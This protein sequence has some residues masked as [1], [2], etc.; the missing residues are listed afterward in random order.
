MK[1]YE[2]ANLKLTEKQNEAQL[3]CSGPAKYVMLYGGARSGKTFLH[4]RNIV[5][6]GLKSPDSR[7]CIFRLRF[8]HVKSSIVLDTFPKVMR[9]AFPGVEYELNR[10][11]YYSTFDN[12]AVIWFGGL[13]DKD[14][15]EKILG[16][17]FCTIYINEASQI[18]WLAVSYAITRLAQQSVQKIEG[19]NIAPLK[20]RMLFDCNPPNKA[21]WTYSLFVKKIHPETRLPLTNP[22]EYACFKMNP[23]DNVDNLS[24]DYLQTLNSL[25]PRLRKRFLDGEFADANPNALFTDETMMPN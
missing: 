2:R 14:R 12:G 17:E 24:E 21:H 16:L 10:S 6:R 25:S 4:V 3:V 5:F 9:T 22:E 23:A 13:D 11:D 18:S 15:T 8:N 20:S 1:T 19:R 7:H